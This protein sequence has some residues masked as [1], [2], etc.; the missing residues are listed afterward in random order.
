METVIFGRTQRSTYFQILYVPWK[1][2]RE[3]TRR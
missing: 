1:D 2:E 3:P